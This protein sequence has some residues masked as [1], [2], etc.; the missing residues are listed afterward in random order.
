MKYVAVLQRESNGGYVVS[1]PVLP[2]CV[3]QGDNQDE[4]LANIREAMEL[5][6]EDCRLA[7]DPIPEEDSVAYV[8]LTTS[9]NSAAI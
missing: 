9:G 8:K 5:Y 1:V 6:L 2:G 4:A 7:G 3:S